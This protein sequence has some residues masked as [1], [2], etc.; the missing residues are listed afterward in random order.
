MWFEIHSF[1]LTSIKNIET[2]QKYYSIS[3]GEA[4]RKSRVWNGSGRSCQRGAPVTSTSSLPHPTSSRPRSSS[5]SWVT[6]TASWTTPEPRR[7]VESQG[8]WEKSSSGIRRRNKKENLENRFLNPEGKKDRNDKIII[9]NDTPWLRE[10]H[11]WTIIKPK[12]SY[13]VL[14]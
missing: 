9:R 6:P 12:L 10:N 7:R 4:H 5:S 1:K 2:A 11:H 8:G 14:F 13:W 3:R